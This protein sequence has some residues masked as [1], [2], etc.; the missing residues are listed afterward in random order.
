MLIL[1]LQLYFYFPSMQSGSFYSVQVFLL[2]RL[3]KM[4]KEQFRFKQIFAQRIMNK[5]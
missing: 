5:V 1:C 3:Q 2:E 4:F